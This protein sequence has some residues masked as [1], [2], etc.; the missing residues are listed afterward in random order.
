MET[1]ADLANEAISQREKAGEHPLELVAEARA[2]NNTG[3]LEAQAE[4]SWEHLVAEQRS[5]RKANVDVYLDDFISVVQGGPRER[6]QMLRHL[7]HQIE[8][9]F[10]PNKEAYTN[11]K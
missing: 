2:A 11:R 8:Q 6:R 3:N 7:F 1:V 9:V 5:A 4:A 10:R